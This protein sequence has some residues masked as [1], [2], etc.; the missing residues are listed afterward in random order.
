MPPRQRLDEPWATPAQLA[1]MTSRADAFQD[2]IDDEFGRKRFWVDFREE[3][4][5]QWDM[6]DRQ[7]KRF[8]SY[9]RD[10]MRRRGALPNRARQPKKAEKA[11]RLPLAATTRHQTEEVDQLKSSQASSRAVED[12][13]LR[14]I[15]PPSRHSPTPGPSGV[16]RSPTPAK[17]PTP[18][19]SPPSRHS[20]T[21]G[22]SGVPRS[23]TPAKWPTPVLSPPSRHSPTPGPSGVPHSPT[24]APTR[25]QSPSPLLVDSPL[26][27]HVQPSSPALSYCDV[28]ASPTPRPSPIPLGRMP[29]VLPPSSIWAK[30]VSKALAFQLELPGIEHEDVEVVVHGQQLAVYAQ[31]ERAQYKWTTDVGGSV[32]RVHCGL[33]NGALRMLVKVMLLEDVTDERRIFSVDDCQGNLSAVWAS[34]QP[35]L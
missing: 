29:V 20:P 28:P 31:N 8:A 5:S 13:L 2:T 23:P 11:T 26:A 9:F 6:T 24:P 22:P 19:L 10:E 21:P 30:D 17:W 32:K 18:V 27:I 4:L 15:S 12:L 3:W 25:I 14:A 1:F 34:R 7:N 16:P 35:A 33:E